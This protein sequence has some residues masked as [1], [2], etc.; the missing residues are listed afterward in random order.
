MSGLVVD[1]QVPCLA[2]FCN[3]GVYTTGEV[4]GDFEHTTTVAT[5]TTVS[6]QSVYFG[7][8]TIHTKDGD[9]RCEDSGAITTGSDGAGVHLCRIVGGTGRYRN[10]GG[11]LQERFFYSNSRILIPNGGHGGGDY[12]GVIRLADGAAKKL[13]R[14][15]SWRPGQAK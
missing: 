2:I 10:A 1:H 14:R 6:G 12:V 4:Q 13:S 9:I 8:G 3:A 11:Y 15:T 7:Y 5:P